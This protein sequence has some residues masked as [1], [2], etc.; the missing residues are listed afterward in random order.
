[1]PGA[2][3]HPESPTGPN[4]MTNKTAIFYN[5]TDKPF[6]GYW[7]GKPKTIKAG[8]KE[9]MPEFLAR[10]F[11]K[12]LANQVLIEQGKYNYTSPKFPEQVPAFM[13]LF[14]KAFILEDDAEDQTEVEME[15]DVANRRHNNREEPSLNIP[16]T[17]KQSAPT[18]PKVVENAPTQNE[19]IGDTDPNEK[20]LEDEFEGVN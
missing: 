18:T 4:T 16:E 2:K 15:I 13:Q 10:H 3:P 20:D 1:M 7:D 17:P 11:A 5:F 12:H 8:R 14:T 9:Y 6:T 19:K